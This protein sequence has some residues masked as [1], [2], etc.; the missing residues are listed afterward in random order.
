[1]ASLASLISVVRDGMLGHIV[2]LL[3]QRLMDSSVLALFVPMAR[4]TMPG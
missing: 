3:I 1:M 4:R 2:D